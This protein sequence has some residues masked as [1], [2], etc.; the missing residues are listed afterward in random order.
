MSGPKYCR[1]VCKMCVGKIC[2]S[3]DNPVHVDWSLLC[4]SLI[5]SICIWVCFVFEFCVL[6]S[7][8]GL[9]S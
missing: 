6:F 9:I 4:T 7:P 2:S 8:N 3:N 1:I 5:V